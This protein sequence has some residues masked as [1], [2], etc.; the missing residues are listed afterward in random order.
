MKRTLEF[1]KSALFMAVIL[2]AGIALPS[3]LLAQD[4]AGGAGSYSKLIDINFGAHQTPD[5]L[6]YP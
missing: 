1:G 2:L 5:L 3:K 4:L 6:T